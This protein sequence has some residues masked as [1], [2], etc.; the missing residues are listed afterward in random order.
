[1]EKK[2]DEYLIDIA[3]GHKYENQTDEYCEEYSK[4]RMNKENPYGYQFV[5]DTREHTYVEGAGFLE[6][7]PA[8]AERKS[9]IKC[10][11]LLG[12]ALISMILIDFAKVALLKYVF[13]FTDGTTMYYSGLYKKEIFAPQVLI[14][15][16][17]F[18]ILKYL[19][20]IILM[21]RISKIPRK[22]MVP[23]SGKKGDYIFNCVIIMLAVVAIGRISNYVFAHLLNFV[24]MDSVYYDYLYSDNLSVMLTFAVCQ[25]FIVP[26]FME[27]FF[28]GVVLQ[29]FRQFGDLFAVMLTSIVSCL[30]SYNF[31]QMVYV[32]CASVVVGVFTIKTGSIQTA[33]AMRIAGRSMTYFITY[34]MTSVDEMSGKIFECVMVLMVFA[35]AVFVFSRML[36]AGQWSFSIKA[37][38]SNLNNDQKIRTML[39]SALLS[40]WAIG[41]IVLTILTL[42]FV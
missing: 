19:V 13:N 23:F 12:I 11:T 40:F 28:R 20:P 18:G 1:M 36:N 17:I 32:F 2:N 39:S 6:K 14:I 29:T 3:S 31:S 34:V 30:C 10:C 7:K 5:H 33:F 35:A 24:R 41:A 9:L 26:I 42:R 21:K 37:E 4:W 38:D 16:M 25:C 15:N 8:Q 22:V 27:I